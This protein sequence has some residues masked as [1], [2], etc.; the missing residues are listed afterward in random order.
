MNVNG[1]KT[2]IDYIKQDEKEL[3]KLLSLQSLHLISKNNK[4][5]I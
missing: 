3:Q 1:L 2:L 5:I 4:E